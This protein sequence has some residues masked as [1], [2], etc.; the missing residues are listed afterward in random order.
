MLLADPAACQGWKVRLA[1]PAQSVPVTLHVELRRARI[2]SKRAARSMKRGQP[3]HTT[4]GDMNQGKFTSAWLCP[5][6]RWG[7][8]RHKQLAAMAEHRPVRIKVR[9]HRYLAWVLQNSA[10]QEQG[11]WL[12]DHLA[13]CEPCRTDFAQ[14][15]RLRHAMSLPTD[16]SIDANAGLQRLR[17]T[18]GIRLAES[19]AVSS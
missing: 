9:P 11:E 5:F 18:R 7:F 13:H 4:V 1:A 19:V 2:R 16:I 6:P 3:P 8:V 17:A 15:S 14:R 12:E 10:T